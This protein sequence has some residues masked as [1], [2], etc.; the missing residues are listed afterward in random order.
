MYNNFTSSFQNCRKVK[1]PKMLRPTSKLLSYHMRYARI[2]SSLAKPC[3]EVTSDYLGSEQ[4]QA[5]VEAM[6]KKLFK[7]SHLNERKAITANQL[8]IDKQMIVMPNMPHYRDH[9]SKLTQAFLGLEDEEYHNKDSF[10]LINPVIKVRNTHFYEENL[11]S[12]FS[13]PWFQ[14]EM[15]RY[16]WITL[17]FTC[18]DTGERV[19]DLELDRLDGVFIQ[20]YV[21]LLHGRT[22]IDNSI[23]NEMIFKGEPYPYEIKLVSSVTSRHG[24]RLNNLVSPNFWAFVLK[25]WM[26]RRY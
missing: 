5:D 7:A 13:C 8:G 19:E 11:E 16:S 3:S 25:V 18:G 15:P 9:N 23:D 24:Y 20:Q 12:C 21:D 22:I 4:Y 1:N 6:R 2:H 10:V 26:L 17:S 14:I